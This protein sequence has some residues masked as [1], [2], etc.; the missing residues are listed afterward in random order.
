MG[1]AGKKEKNNLKYCLGMDEKTRLISVD[2]Y[3]AEI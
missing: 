3:R 2:R 1:E